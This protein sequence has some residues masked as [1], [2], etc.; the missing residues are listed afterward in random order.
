MDIEF[1]AFL[2]PEV[3]G[4]D[5]GAVVVDNLNVRRCG[6][7]VFELNLGVVVGAGRARL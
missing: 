6:E 4:R 1:M 5:G 7:V 2:T 3:D